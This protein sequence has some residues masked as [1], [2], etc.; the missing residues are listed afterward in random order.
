MSLEEQ[1][2]D[3]IAEGKKVYDLV[4][5]KFGEWDNS[6]KNQIKKLEDWKNGFQLNTIFKVQGEDNKFYPIFVMTN[7]KPVHLTIT[8]DSVHWDSTWH[9]RVYYECKAFTTHEGHS[10]SF[11]KDIAYLTKQRHFIANRTE[12][13]QD[14]ILVFWLRGNAT[15]RLVGENISLG[16][17]KAEA[18]SSRKHSY[19]V[20]D[21]TDENMKISTFNSIG[22]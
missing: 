8:R 4:V 15:Y 18:K 1:I 9:G 7:Y 12:D 5:G 22:G 21:D 6:V 10:A 19:E 14:G 2:A 17:Y 13:Y 11:F 16:N 20:I 3:S